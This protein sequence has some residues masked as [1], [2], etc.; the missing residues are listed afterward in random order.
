MNHLQIASGTGEGNYYEIDLSSFIKYFKLDAQQV[1][2]VLKT[3]EQEGLLYFNEQV[4]LA[5]KVQVVATKET[6]YEF[7]K[8][9][10]ALEPVLKALLRSYEG[11]IDQPVN[12]YEKQLA[13]NLKQPAEVVIEQLHQLHAH[14]IIRFTPQ[15]KNR[16]FIYYRTGFSRKTCV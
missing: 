3:L 10:I 7:E 11:I 16:R 15:R 4:F 2:S 9:N 12:I 14:S 8:Y 1:V 13:W 6:L 5:S